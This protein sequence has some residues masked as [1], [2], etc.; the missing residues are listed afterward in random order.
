MQVCSKT[1]N[2]C[3]R[4]PYYRDEMCAGCI[5]CCPLVSHG[6]YANGTDRQTDA[7]TDGR[8][9]SYITFSAGCGV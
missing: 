2:K 8:Q 1:L 7:R 3:V 9:N 4:T 6:E 5:V